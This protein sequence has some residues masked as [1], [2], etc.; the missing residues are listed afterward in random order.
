MSAATFGLAEYCSDFGHVPNDMCFS[1]FSI[2]SS[3]LAILASTVFCSVN[4]LFRSRLRSSFL[5]EHCSFVSFADS[6]YFVGLCTVVVVAMVE[7]CSPY[8]YFRSACRDQAV[9]GHSSGR[10]RYQDG[11]LAFLVA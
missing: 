1:S 10:Y 6:F 2:E 9:V 3:V 8:P 5:E 4:F 11:A 7:D